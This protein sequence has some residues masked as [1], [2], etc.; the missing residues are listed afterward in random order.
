MPFFATKHGTVKVT[1]HSRLLDGF[2][3][4]DLSRGMLISALMY[5]FNATYFLSTVAWPALL[6][7]YTI[8]A[9]TGQSDAIECAPPWTQ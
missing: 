4:S 6:T 3:S 2:P 9:S 5:A 7:N 1:M 8:H